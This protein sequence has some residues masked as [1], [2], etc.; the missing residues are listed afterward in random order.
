LKTYKF[1][2]LPKEIYYIDKLPVKLVE[3]DIQLIVISSIL[4][5]LIATIYPAYKASKLQPVEALRYE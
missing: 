1:I 5:S 2:T 3:G 4:I